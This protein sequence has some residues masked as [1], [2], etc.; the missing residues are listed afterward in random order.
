MTTPSPIGVGVGMGIGA[1]A[2][3]ASRVGMG[4]CPGMGMGICPGMGMGICPGIGIG[5]GRGI[6]IGIG[7]TTG[8]DASID[9]GVACGNSSSPHPGSDSPAAAATSSAKSG[10]CTPQLVY[11]TALERQIIFR[12]AG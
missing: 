4:I 5:A 2:D 8:A 6:G 7:M 12:P 1:G 9:A 10:L 11:V 3:P